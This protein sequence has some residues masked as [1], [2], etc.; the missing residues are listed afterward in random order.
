M[1]GMAAAGTILS[2]VSSVSDMANRYQNYQTQASAADTNAAISKTNAQ[3]IL[4]QGNYAQD[5]K[6]QEG[7]QYISNQYVRN[8]Q[9]GAA[10]AGTTG[11]KAVAKSVY[12]LEKDLALIAYN[13]QTKATDYLN[14]AKMYQYESKVAKANAANSLIS[15]GL[16]IANNLLVSKKPTY[17]R[18]SKLWI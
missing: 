5:A 3:N 7:K 4:I 9:A 15:G 2:V 14:Q 8:L 12:N 10:G 16:N 6:L 1:A 11:D 17:D 18:N 13:Y